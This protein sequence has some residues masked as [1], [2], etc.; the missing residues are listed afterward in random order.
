M[1]Q[2]PRLQ[3]SYRAF[4]LGNRNVFVQL[5]HS[6]PRA[7][8]YSMNVFIAD[9]SDVLKGGMGIA[10]L[11][12]IVFIC[13]MSW[14]WCYRIAEDKGY[15]GWAFV[16][17]GLCISPVIAWIIVILLPRNKQKIAD[18][19]RIPCPECGEFIMPTAKTCRFCNVIVTNKDRNKMLRKR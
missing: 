7:E 10:I 1:H 5:A 15:P 3:A 6:A 16:L 4:H 11:L 19:R 12:G 9:V 8:S 2:D 14:V 18:K 17:A 13:I